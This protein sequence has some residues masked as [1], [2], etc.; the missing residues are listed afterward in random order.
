M[1]ESQ[2]FRPSPGKDSSDTEK[3]RLQR[4]FDRAFNDELMRAKKRVSIQ[5]DLLGKPKCHNKD[6]LLT[7]SYL[8]IYA[9]KVNTRSVHF[10]KRQVDMQVSI[11]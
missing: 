9:V 5:F 8:I 7:Y 6:K 10:V 4:F 2:Y 1:G 3:I 11:A